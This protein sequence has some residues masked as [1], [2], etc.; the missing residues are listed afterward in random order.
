[1]GRV[2]N[3]STPYRLYSTHPHSDI[4]SFVRIHHPP[5]FCL[6]S[7]DH[8]THVS[9]PLRASVDQTERPQGVM[10]SAVASAGESSTSETSVSHSREKI[11][12]CCEIILDHFGAIA[13]VSAKRT[14]A[15]EASLSLTCLHH[16]L[17]ISQQVACTL[18]QRGRLTLRELS[19]FLATPT[20]HAPTGYV[21]E[22]DDVAQAEAAQMDAWSGAALG[23]AGKGAA[24]TSASSWSTPL[25]SQRLIQQALLTLIQ[26]HLCWHA[27]PL[28]DGT[29]VQAPMDDSTSAEDAFRGMEYFQINVEEVLPRLRFGTYLAF[30]EDRFGEVGA[31]IVNEILRHGKLRATDVVARISHQGHPPDLIQDTLRDL[32]FYAYIQPSLAKAHISPRDRRIAYEAEIVSRERK[33]LGPKDKMRIALAAQDRLHDDDRE[34]WFTTPSDQRPVRR[35]LYVRPTKKRSATTINGRSRNGKSAKKGKANDENARKS[36][37]TIESSDDESDAN[38]RRSLSVDPNVFLRVNFDRFDL[39]IRNELIVQAAGSRF[40]TPIAS[41]LQVMMQFDMGSY[42][43]IASSRDNCSTSIHVNTLRQKLPP[44]LSLRD[45]FDRDTLRRKLGSDSSTS[46]AALLGEV[47]AVL[48]GAGDE[49][50]SGRTKRFIGPA[51]NARTN[52]NVGGFSQVQVEYRN[53]ARTMR[54]QIL[55]NVVEAQFGRPGARVMS[56]LNELGKLD[57]KQ[58]SKVCLMS[59]SETRDVCARLFAAG[60]LSLQEVPKSSE[61]VAARSFFFWYVDERKCIAWL[62]DRLCKTLARLAQRRRHELA[63]EADLMA[64]A[65]RSDMRND[66]SLLRDIE[67]LRL[68]RVRQTVD[69]ISLAELRTWHDLFI[70]GLLPE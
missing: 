13:A 5:R 15:I 40:N 29:L 60:L 58:I 61:R 18:L 39:H 37:L 17:L 22:Q 55:R 48:L 16:C 68:Q 67:R 66:E 52:V 35:G 44:G 50:P 54:H 43:T 4:L 46:D 8:T 64:K 70:A 53:A 1:M 63:R 69:I 28:P 59:M 11:S 2:R 30:A 34:I 45:A 65:L 23:N 9:V 24:S 6:A 7:A 26:H 19:R 27:R 20:L 42:E 41:V 3:L 31:A 25:R 10:A 62:S 33:L 47:I 12:L 51:E 57:E 49:S 38:S 36:L 32:L 56:L 14:W 21:P